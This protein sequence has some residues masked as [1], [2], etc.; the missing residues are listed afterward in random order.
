[1]E[2]SSSLLL[3]FICIPCSMK[4]MFVGWLSSFPSLVYNTPEAR[5]ELIRNVLINSP[6]TLISLA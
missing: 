5:F 1:M 3:H 6:T 2:D 4:E